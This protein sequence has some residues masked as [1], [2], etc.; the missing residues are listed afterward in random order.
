MSINRHLI[1]CLI[2]FRLA[3]DLPVHFTK[4]KDGWGVRKGSVAEMMKKCRHY[5]RL[6]IP[7]AVFPEGGRS[8]NGTPLPFKDG[9]FK[10]AVETQ[11]T[12]QVG[13]RL[14]FGKMMMSFPRCH[15]MIISFRLGNAPLTCLLNRSI[16]V[17]PSLVS[18]PCALSGSER[19]WPMHHKLF[20][21]ATVFVRFGSPISSEGHTA[22][23]LRDATRSA[24]TELMAALPPPKLAC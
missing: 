15:F 14:T 20:A 12:I 11:A 24:I 22:E 17:P 18:Q 4:D 9:F 2:P 10:L 16:F 7:L 3:G 13:G 23:S 5:L 21:P 19:A 8:H 6:G 1:P